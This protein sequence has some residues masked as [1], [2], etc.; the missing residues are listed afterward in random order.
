MILNLSSK[1]TRIKLRPEIR[2]VYFRIPKN[3]PWSAYIEGSNFTQNLYKF[4]LTK[5]NTTLFAKY[6][7]MLHQ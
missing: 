3:Q 1:K 7:L 6:I 2:Q 5:N 4:N